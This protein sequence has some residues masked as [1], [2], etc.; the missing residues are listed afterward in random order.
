MANGAQGGERPIGYWLKCADDAITRRVNDSLK[1]LGLTRLHWQALH[2]VRVAGRTTVLQLA[3]ELRGFADE[4]GLETLVESLMVRGYVARV[5]GT[6]R[7]ESFELTAAG[8]TAYTQALE[9]QTEVRQRMMEGLSREDYQTVIR[10]LQA[11]I[12]N[13]KHEASAGSS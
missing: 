13:L 8:Q 2:V 1:R 12:A 6:S 11:M 10:V 5:S 7:V 3:N 9:V 4:A